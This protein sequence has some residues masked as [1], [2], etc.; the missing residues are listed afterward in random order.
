ME[1]EHFIECEWVQHVCRSKHSHMQVNVGASIEYLNSMFF[2]IRASLRL[3]YVDLSGSSSV[4]CT[5]KSGVIMKVG[6]F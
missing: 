3:Y 1:K 6:G 4:C 5:D 2:S